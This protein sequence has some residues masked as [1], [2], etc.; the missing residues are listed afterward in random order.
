[1]WFKRK[2]TYPP[3]QELATFDRADASMARMAVT[4][5]DTLSL[6]DE[7]RQYSRVPGLEE[8]PV[9][10]LSSDELYEAINRYLLLEEYRNTLFFRDKPQSYSY[11]IVHESNP[12]RMSMLTIIPL[13]GTARLLAGPSVAKCG[14]SR[15][16]LWI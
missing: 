2:R 5:A 3:E 1:M 4:I 14:E 8:D 11:S 15:Y 7:V 16:A 10:A 6:C 9:F 12:D 13:G